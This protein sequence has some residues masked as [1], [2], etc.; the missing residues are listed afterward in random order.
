MALYGDRAMAAMTA[1]VK[2]G[3]L[4]FSEPTNLPEGATVR[5]ETVDGDDLDDEERAQLHQSI[6]VGIAEAER[7][8]TISVA[9]LWA[10]LDRRP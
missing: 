10:R 9:E 2:G 6:D 8:Q 7:G 1:Q 4:V 5:V 3:R